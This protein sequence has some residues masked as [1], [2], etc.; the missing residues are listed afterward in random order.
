M[1]E[2]FEYMLDKNM[3]IKVYVF[4]ILNQHY[5]N[6]FSFLI[7]QPRVVLSDF[8]FNKSMNKLG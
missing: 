6:Q 7:Q 4:Q 2:F 8:Y 3:K 1:M 5:F